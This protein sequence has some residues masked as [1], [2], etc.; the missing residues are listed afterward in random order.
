MR[1]H[2]FN[3]LIEI[4]DLADSKRRIVISE[5]S[6]SARQAGKCLYKVRSWNRQRA[7]KNL[8]A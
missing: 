3:R 6:S 7:A 8:L 2:F 5:A 4:S 1:T